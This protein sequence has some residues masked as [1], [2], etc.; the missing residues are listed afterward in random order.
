MF[1]LLAMGFR[2]RM[3][4]V[5]M[6]N[7]NLSHYAQNSLSILGMNANLAWDYREAKT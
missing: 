6:A 2:G 5:R 3:A 1:F 4:M 7:D